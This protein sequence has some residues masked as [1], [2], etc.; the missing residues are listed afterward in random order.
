M[1]APAASARE[2][3]EMSFKLLLIGDS[4]TSTKQPRQVATACHNNTSTPPCSPV[5]TIRHMYAYILNDALDSAW[6]VARSEGVGK[7]GRPCLLH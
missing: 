5:I 7:R 1:T 4:G 3:V 2:T 6:V